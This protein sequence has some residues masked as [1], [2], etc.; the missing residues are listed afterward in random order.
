[1]ASL[2]PSYHIFLFLF[3]LGKLGKIDKGRVGIWRLTPLGN[4]TVSTV[5]IH[6]CLLG[7]D[8]TLISKE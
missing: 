6:V 4:D 5:S 7:I 2:L 3:Y 1:M 8:G